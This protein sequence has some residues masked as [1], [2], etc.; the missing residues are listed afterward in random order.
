MI[1]PDCNDPVPVT[2]IEPVSDR[3]I[4]W[5]AVIAPVA[6]TS[7]DPE[8]LRLDVFTAVILAVAVN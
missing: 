3:D 6:V 7:I 2:E 1:T 5:I 8:S 4:V